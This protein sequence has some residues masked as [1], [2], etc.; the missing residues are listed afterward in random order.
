[1]CVPG[2]NSVG[3]GE[4]EICTEGVPVPL[5]VM[6]CVPGVALSVSVIVPDLIP[7][8]VGVKVIDKL[9]LAPGATDA[10]HVFVTA[11]SPPGTMLAISRGEE[12][13][14]VKVTGCAAL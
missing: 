10:P 12:P 5:R 6:V 3:V 1:M 14:L 2:R 13:A 4:R 7:V 9:Q 11:K 8:A